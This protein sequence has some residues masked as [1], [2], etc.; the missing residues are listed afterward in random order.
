MRKQILSNCRGSKC[1]WPTNYD[2]KR[3]ILAAS[4]RGKIASNFMRHWY[5]MECMYFTYCWPGHFVGC[6]ILSWL[7]SKL[8][9][10]TF[11]FCLKIAIFSTF[12]L[13]LGLMIISFNDPT[14]S[15]ASKSPPALWNDGLLNFNNSRENVK[16]FATGSE[17]GERASFF[18]NYRQHHSS[19]HN[20]PSLQKQK[21][22]GQWMIN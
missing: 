19:L 11:L 21:G 8:K 12:T 20:L 13:W 17:V 5:R 16:I 14:P 4:V 7:L 2:M 15:F 1:L 10:W 18:A 22:K 6:S 3:A 9:L